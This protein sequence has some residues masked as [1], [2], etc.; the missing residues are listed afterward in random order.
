MY[1][2]LVPASCPVALASAV[3]CPRLVLPSLRVGCGC[4]VGL[5]S[6]AG[7]ATVIPCTWDE[8]FKS[9]FVTLKDDKKMAFFRES[10]TVNCNAGVRGTAKLTSGTY[11]WTVGKKDMAPRCCCVLLFAL[12]LT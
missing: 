1:A 5:L 4:A 10:T 8:G 2:E 3:G 7:T 12:G 9:T 6:P 11:K